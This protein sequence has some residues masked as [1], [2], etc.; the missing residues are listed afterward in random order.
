[1]IDFQVMHGNIMATQKTTKGKGNSAKKSGSSG[2]TSKAK[3]NSKSKQKSNGKQIKLSFY[4]SH[5]TPIMLVYLALSVVFTCFIFIKGYNVWAR[6]RGAFFGF[7]GIGFCVFTLCLLIMGIRIALNSLKRHFMVSTVSGFVLSSVFSSFLHLFTNSISGGGMQEWS[8]QLKNAAE[9]GWNISF[10]GLS[11]TGGIVGAFMGGG[12]MHLLGKAGAFVVLAVILIFSLIFYFDISFNSVGNHVSSAI[13]G[14][15]DKLDVGAA[16][17]KEKRSERKEERK[18][19]RQQIAEQRAAEEEERKRQQ[20]AENEDFD[21]AKSDVET[22]FHKSAAKAVKREPRPYIPQDRLFTEYPKSGNS[23]SETKSPRIGYGVIDVTPEPSFEEPNSGDVIDI[24]DSAY[25]DVKDEIFDSHDIP[26]GYEEVDA[27]LSDDARDIVEAAIDSANANAEKNK[28]EVEGYTEDKSPKR[29]Y[30]FPP[31]DCL[32]EPDFSRE[33]D[34]ALEMKT[35]AKKLVDTLKSFGVETTLIGVS[36]GPSVT[37]YELQ[38][39][40]GVKISKITNLAD[41]IALNLASSGVRIEAP[42]PNKSAVG[43]EVP[44]Q[45]R[46][47]VTF[48]EIISASEFKKSK[49]KLNVALGKDISGSV[50]CADLAKMPHLLIAGTTGSGKSVCLNCMIT[51]ILYNAKPTEVKLL[52]IDPK[53]VEFSVYNGIPHLLVPVISDVRKAAGSLAWAVVEME[54]RYKTFSTCGVRDIGGFNKYVLEHPEHEPMP[55]I[56]IFID[57]LNDLMMVS[58]KEV[59]DSIC[60]LA[61]KARAAGMHLVVATQRPSVDVITGIIKANIPSRISLSVSSQVDSRTILDTIGAEKLLGNGDMLYN[62]VGFS[63][64]VRIQGAYLSDGEIEKIVTFIKNEVEAEY[65][66]DVMEEIERNAVADKKAQPTAS[67]GDDADSGD[68]MFNRALKIAVDCGAASAS[69]FQRKLRIGYARAARIMDELD[70]RGYIGPAETGGKP[71]KVLLTSAQY[72]EMTASRGEPS[73]N[74]DDF[75]VLSD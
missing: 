67:A 18:I 55:Q 26:E 68:D 25:E 22:D 66:S 15:K 36:R 23:S 57:E 27:E 34:Y 56:V 54:N 39:A 7:F 4:D 3:S 37:R 24:P 71:R 42:I 30:A 64:P 29:E 16:N 43:I 74:D 21:F 1:M 73:N 40:P 72:L 53:Q 32:A 52:M 2:K 12:L 14:G 5:R 65:D 33:G 60:R 17:F 59:E 13:N 75:D 46:S 61:Q 58:P 20:I 11:V 41:D 19:R 49:S 51:S 69:L 50:L 31:I 63:K 8:L 35:I 10:D 62:P 28:N 44:N 6:I 47:T 38:P 70:E 45:I 9:L 48:R